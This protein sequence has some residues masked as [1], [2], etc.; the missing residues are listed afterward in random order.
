MPEPKSE[1][2]YTFSVVELSDQ[3]LSVVKNHKSQPKKVTKAV[4]FGCKVKHTMKNKFFQPIL[5]SRFTFSIVGFFAFFRL[6]CKKSVAY[7]MQHMQKQPIFVDFGSNIG[8]GISLIFNSST[9][10]LV[11]AGPTLRPIDPWLD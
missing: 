7:H 2:I 11:Y 5:F 1:L 9:A 8:S 4:A 10:G 3:S 6:K